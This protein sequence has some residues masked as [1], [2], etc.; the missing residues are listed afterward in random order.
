MI[1]DT[2]FSADTV[3]F[4][5][6]KQNI[7]LCSTYQL[8][9]EEDVVG[10]KIR[11]GRIYLMQCQPE[12]IELQRKETAAVLDAKWCWKLL[13]DQSL[14]G[15]V[16]AKGVLSLYGLNSEEK[17]EEVNS[18]SPRDDGVLFLS[19]DW[20]NRIAEVDPTIA[21]SQSNGNISLWRLANAQLLE[22]GNW[23]AHDFEAWITAFDYW[24]PNTVY[25]G[26]DDALFKSW[27]IRDFSCSS[28]SRRHSMGVCS[29]QSHPRKE[30]ILATGSYDEH[31]LIWDKRNF[32]KPLSDT[33]INGG[34]WR[35]KW[36]PF[37]DKN[38]SDYIST[39]SMHAG[40]HV[41]KIDENGNGSV[42]ETNTS[43]ESLGYGI[44]WQ[45][46][47]GNIEQDKALLACCS[48]YDHKLSVWKVTLS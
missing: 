8:S 21:V 23:K 37:H 36:S 2:E 25:S 41:L 4:N 6:F 13:G 32:K 29:I 12:L 27:D 5:P 39:A 38:G 40:F 31:V 22:I 19:L 28:T 15:I 10:H 11:K 47:M 26:G 35:I 9:S 33:H 48:F 7:I 45:N 1:F 44:D 14:A 3:E 16:D 34:V 42:I 18:S 46:K 20:N 17:F 30:Y 43:H 24:D